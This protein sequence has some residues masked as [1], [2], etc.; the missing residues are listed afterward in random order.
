MVV[1]Y[2]TFLSK[3]GGC[4][5]GL[6][7]SM[8]LLVEA[9][10]CAP[11]YLTYLPG[12]VRNVGLCHKLIRE[13]KGDFS[14]LTVA[15]ICEA[16]T[17]DAIGSGSWHGNAGSPCPISNSS[18]AIYTSQWYGF[19]LGTARTQLLF[20]FFSLMLSHDCAILSQLV[21][22]GC[23]NLL[24]YPAGATSICCAVF[25]TVTAV[26][27]PEQKNSC[28][29]HENKERLKGNTNGFKA[30]QRCA[31]RVDGACTQV[32]REEVHTEVALSRVSTRLD[33]G[34]QVQKGREQRELLPVP[35]VPSSPTT[36][37]PP[38]PPPPHGQATVA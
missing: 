11:I 12:G 19:Q 24:M 33:R 18:C 6:S 14:C 34:T 31:R 32:A 28:N 37:R 15:G 30:P 27:A 13:R 26:P 38:P 35:S 16:S 3:G 23:R 21:Y 22:S 5:E 4:G 2:V 9:D 17:S 25:N 20:E 8:C 7:C 10:C 1:L 36:A 29:V